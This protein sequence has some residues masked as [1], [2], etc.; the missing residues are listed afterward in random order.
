VDPF[1]LAWKAREYDF[2]TE[3]IELAGK[4][5]VNMPYFVSGLVGREI[6]RKGRSIKCA[7][8]L[9][10]GVAYKPDV[11]DTRETPAAKL[12]ELLREEGADVIYHDPFVPTFMV[13]GVELCSVELAEDTLS[14]CDC[15][16]IVTAHSGVDYGIIARSG[17]PVLD[18]RNVLRKMK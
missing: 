16:V 10:V 12:M 1:Y 8:V 5:N 9:V 2:Q 14:D 17:I 11:G 4:V 6:N 18:T 3:F 7:R 15:A 13:G